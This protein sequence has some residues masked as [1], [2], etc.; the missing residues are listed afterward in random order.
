MKKQ[1][2]VIILVVVFSL[3]SSIVRADKFWS[4]K[5]INASESQVKAVSSSISQCVDGLNGYFKDKP[6]PILIITY[7]SRNSFVECALC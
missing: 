6:G 7:G 4:I 3:L 5:N 1:I 2:L